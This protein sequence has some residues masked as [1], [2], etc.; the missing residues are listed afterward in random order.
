MSTECAYVCDFVIV[1]DINYH[2]YC[3]NRLIYCHLLVFRVINLFTEEILIALVC[4]RRQPNHTPHKPALVVQLLVISS[5]KP[6][7][8]MSDDKNNSN[9]SRYAGTGYSTSASAALHH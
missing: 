8:L 2:N 6:D 7:R 4:H 3:I 1:S 5:P 9:F